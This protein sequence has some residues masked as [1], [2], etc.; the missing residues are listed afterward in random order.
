MSY[1]VK[2]SDVIGNNSM[3]AFKQVAFNAWTTSSKVGRRLASSMM[4]L[5]NTAYKVIAAAMSK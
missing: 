3:S 2:E 4:R 1:A 5:F